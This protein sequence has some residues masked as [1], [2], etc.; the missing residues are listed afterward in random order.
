MKSFNFDL[1]NHYLKI[2]ATLVMACLA[3]IAITSF[4]FTDRELQAVV[5]NIGGFGLFSGA[6]IYVIGRFVR[7]KRARAQA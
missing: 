1:S 7:A 3:A 2:G 4:F 6:V 5:R